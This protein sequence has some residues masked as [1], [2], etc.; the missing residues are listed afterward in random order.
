MNIRPADLP[1]LMSLNALLEESNV[2]RAAARLHLSQPALSA[3]L[4]RLRDMFGDPLLVPSETGR[5]MVPTSKGSSLK[6]PLRAALQQLNQAISDEGEFDPHTS[7][8]CF[9]IAANDN[10]ISM[11]GLD[12]IRNTERSGFHG[13]K[14]AFCL[15]DPET[16][17]AR[18]ERDEVDLLLATVRII[19]NALKTRSLST[20]RY[21]MAQRK[22]HPRGKHPPSLDEYCELKHV[23]VSTTGG[24]QSFIDT[25]L[26]DAGRQRSVTVSVPHYDLVPSIVATTDYVC[27]LPIRFLK[28]FEDQIDI[29]PLPL[30]VPEFTIAQAWHPRSEADSG[31]RWLRDQL[32]RLDR[33]S[34]EGA[35]TRNGSYLNGAAV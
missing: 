24:F 16:I 18:M 1:L 5:G 21:H 23:L 9:T 17:V 32:S 26:A 12:F 29:F 15:P 13:I 22:G 14:I 7:S 20:E 35:R 34:D 28:R 19:P 11:F 30:T 8:R 2:T 31:N 4:A 27:T 3:Q 33:P 25:Q 10:A 6:G